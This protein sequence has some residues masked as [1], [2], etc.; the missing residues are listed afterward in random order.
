MFKEANSSK[1]Q[2]LIFGQNA[3][4]IFEMKTVIIKTIIIIIKRFKKRVSF[5]FFIKNLEIKIF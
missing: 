3:L 5:T 2:I 4:L 1:K